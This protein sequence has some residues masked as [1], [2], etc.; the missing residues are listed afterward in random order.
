[1]GVISSCLSHFISLILPS[2][3]K[4]EI[5]IP[6]I[7]FPSMGQQT[8]INDQINIKQTPI[9]ESAKPNFPDEKRYSLNIQNNDNVSEKNNEFFTPRQSMKNK[10]VRFSLLIDDG[11]SNH[12]YEIPNNNKSSI[13]LKERLKNN[14]F[15]SNKSMDFF[16]CKDSDSKRESLYREDNKFEENYEPSFDFKPIEN[17]AN[18]KTFIESF[19]K[20]NLEILEASQSLISQLKMQTLMN[21]NIFLREMESESSI[22][23]FFL[24]FNDLS[25]ESEF[26]LGS[27][28][29]FD[30][31]RTFILRG[32]FSL[33]CGAE[34]FLFFMNSEKIEKDLF[35]FDSKMVLAQVSENSF[36]YFTNT[37]SLK[38]NVGCNFIVYKVF[39]NDNE[40]LC[41]IN[42]S[43]TDEETI[44]IIKN[45]KNLN[46]F[47]NFD[48]GSFT[49]GLIINRQK[50]G[51]SFKNKGIRIWMQYK[52]NYKQNLAISFAKFMFSDQLKN[53]FEKIR[54][55]FYG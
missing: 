10:N 9:S 40:N 11:T 1:M 21:Y 48:T 22:K 32:G 23:S 25:L 4:K 39:F 51:E 19:Q 38:G 18:Y 33:N 7:E 5:S 47:K 12:S 3:K 42:F 43:L 35:N 31:S 52:I 53:F 44:E 2:N 28:L 29:N 24:V 34:E 8:P 26:Y 16:S 14:S 49:N 41:M 20:E 54:K 15:S 50:N 17:K 46:E 37:S 27:E 30:E 55:R 36:L 45:D 6:L 13:R